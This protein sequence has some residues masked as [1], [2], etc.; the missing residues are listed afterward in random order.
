MVSQWYASWLVT[1]KSNSHF[2][3]VSVER[4]SECTGRQSAVKFV[5]QCT[6]RRV[7]AYHLGLAPQ[8]GIAASHQGS[9][10]ETVLL[11]RPKLFPTRLAVNPEVSD[12][13][14]RES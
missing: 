7:T 9:H 11:Q 12:D 10:L 14:A 2:G 13:E 5:Q 4:V 1:Q 3:V 8:P 6:P